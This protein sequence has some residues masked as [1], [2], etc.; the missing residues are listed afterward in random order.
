MTILRVKNI[1]LGLNYTL[2]IVKTRVR[3]IFP[4][5]ASE[6]CGT[7]QRLRRNLWTLKTSDAW[8]LLFHKEAKIS[9]SKFMQTMLCSKIQSYQVVSHA[10]L[11]WALFM[12]K[13][14]FGIVWYKSYK[15]SDSIVFHFLSIGWIYIVNLVLREHFAAQ[16]A[17]QNWMVNWKW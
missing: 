2:D 12:A 6:W 15:K 1:H 14:S 10:R 9:F 11:W 17:L 13:L 5:S 16:V 4:K 3:S 8:M 7:I